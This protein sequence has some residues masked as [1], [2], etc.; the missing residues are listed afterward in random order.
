MNFYEKRK[1]AFILITVRDRSISTKFLTRT[2]YAV[3]WRLFPKITFPPI[4]AAML[5]FYVK[6]KNAF[7]LEMV[8][9]RAI[10]MEVLTCGVSAQKLIYLGNALTVQDRPISMKFLTCRVYAECTGDF[11]QKSLSHHFWRP[12]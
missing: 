6:R 10:S 7:I 8:Q 12:S 4:L 5:N 1:S 9:D 3:Y 11:S 2:V